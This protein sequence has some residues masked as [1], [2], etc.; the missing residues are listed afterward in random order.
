MTNNQG[1]VAMKL[2]SS[3][4]V[5]ERTGVPYRTLMR[6]VDEGLLDP[7]VRGSR[8][9]Q[10]LFTSRDFLEA[11]II[12]R[13][14]DLMKTED[15]N[16]VLEQIRA[17][18]D[19]LFNSSGFVVICTRPAEHT[20]FGL[21]SLGNW[22]FSIRQKDEVVQLLDAQNSQVTAIPLYAINSLIEDTEPVG[23]INTN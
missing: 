13:F 6:W 14:R 10:T 23:I 9:R 18:D 5:A 22:E 21:G 15:I 1:R 11:V 17:L 20:M 8:G 12:S 16:H 3:L 2:Y 4:E 7:A 19:G